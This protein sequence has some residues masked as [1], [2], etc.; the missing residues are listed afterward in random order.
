M[1][2]ISLI[3]EEFRADNEEEH[4]N[5]ADARTHALRGALE[6]GAE[7]ILGGKMFFAAEVIVSQGNSQERFVVSLGT[8]P[9]K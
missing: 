5:A 8:S 3:N 4:P 7:Q 9:L 1:Y 2:K 6:V